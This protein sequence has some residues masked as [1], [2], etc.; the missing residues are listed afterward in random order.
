[1]PMRVRNQAGCSLPELLVAVTILLIIS[2]A[3]TSGLLQ[4]TSSQKTIW[5]RTQLHAGVRSATELLQQE[6]G[7]AGRVALQGAATQ[8]SSVATGTQSVGINQVIGGV[9]TASVSGIFVNE[10]LT[11][12]AGTASDGTSHY[13]TVTVTA[14]DTGAKTITATFDYTHNAGVPVVPLGGFATG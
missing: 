9:S 2:G 8:A 3:V 11:I 10:Q 4:V 1:M 7:Q 12:D 13:E 14:V 6:V 5:N